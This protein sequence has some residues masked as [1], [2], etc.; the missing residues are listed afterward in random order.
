MVELLNSWLES[1]LE[2]MV[3]LIVSFV[4]L[5]EEQELSKMPL[6]FEVAVELGDGSPVTVCELVDAFI[7]VEEEAGE[8][9]G[10]LILVLV[11]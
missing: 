5:L 3:L 9:N 7:Q 8:C 11:C 6:A 1:L 10:E 2:L 4:L